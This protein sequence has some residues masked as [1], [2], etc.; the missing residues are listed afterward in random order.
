[1]KAYVKHTGK[2]AWNIFW[3]EKTPRKIKKV[4]KKA[5]RAEGKKAAGEKE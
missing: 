4:F 1:M 5:A 3:G 2:A